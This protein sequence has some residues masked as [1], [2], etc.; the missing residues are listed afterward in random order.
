MRYKW[1]LQNAVA[2]SI[3]EFCSRFCELFAKQFRLFM[4]LNKQ[5]SILAAL[6]VYIKKSVCFEKKNK[7]E[8][9]YKSMAKRASCA[10]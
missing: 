1:S 6:F 4:K 7:I 10:L 2:D 9:E 5:T 8:G 3:S